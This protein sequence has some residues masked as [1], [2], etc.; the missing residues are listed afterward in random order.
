MDIK[1]F[2]DYLNEDINVKEVSMFYSPKLLTI[3][4]SIDSKISKELLDVMDSDIQYQMS[5]VDTSDDIDFFS[6]L[7]AN[8][9]GRIEGITE[10]D[11]ED[12]SDNSPVWG[13]KFRQP[14]RIGAFVNRVIPN[15][16]ANDVADFVQTIKGKLDS[17]N[18]TLSIVTGE[19]IRH[20]Y[21]VK[22]YFNPTP[23]LVY[24]DDIEEGSDD[25]RTPLMKSC[26]KQPEK[27][28]FFDIYCK[29]P[30][31]IGMLIMLNKQG[32]LVARALVWFDCFISD[33]PDNPTK[34]VLLDRIYYTQE[35]DV[36]IFINYAKEHGWWYKPKQSKEIY[37]C[38]VNGVESKRPITTRLKNHGDF[39]SYPYVDTL[40]FYT[41]DTGRLST[42]RGKPAMNP[43]TQDIMERYELHK[44]NGGKK[45]LSREK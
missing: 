43:K 6:V 36:Q 2:N 32:Q 13:P 7:P 4:K 35:S 5:Y 1:G 22:T 31:Q 23:G 30:E 8:R 24:R 29:N 45:R 12:P 11:L 37:T 19:K 21:H 38:I 16:N 9:I 33:S 27:Q 3:L 15:C 34:G 25:P 20:W 39:A 18:Y 41:P 26:L 44:T 10:K 42:S 17:S 40:L 14:V 28:G